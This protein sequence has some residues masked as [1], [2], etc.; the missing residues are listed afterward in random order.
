MICMWINR[1]QIR[2]C[3]LV[4]IRVKEPASV[5]AK[6]P[7]YIARTDVYAEQDRSMV[8]IR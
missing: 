1:I 8:R 4:K 3:A 6:L 5:R 2:Y 7:A